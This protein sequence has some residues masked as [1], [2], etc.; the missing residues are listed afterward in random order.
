MTP[1]TRRLSR[2]PIVFWSFAL[3]VGLSGTAAR[4]DPVYSITNLGSGDITLTTASGS[5]F[6]AVIPGGAGI[7]ASGAT[8]QLA[9]VSNGQ[10]SYSFSTTPETTLVQGQGALSNVPLNLD[11]G[12]LTGPFGYSGPN[13]SGFSNV[14]GYAAVVVSYQIANFGNDALQ[15]ATINPIGSNG[16]VNWSQGASIISSPNNGL[17]G[18]Y[19]TITGIN[20]ANQAL[21]GT[22]F[23]T[24]PFDS[25]IYSLS[26][27]SVTDLDTLPAITAGGYSNLKPVAIDD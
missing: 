26:S 17:D 27:K 12:A 3:L 23:G 5:T 6:T 19:I 8:S 18:G 11:S 7:L 2:N 1:R 24:M 20:A 15:F 13:V 14:N 9:S 25:L 22:S 10:V 4:A 16:E 21:V